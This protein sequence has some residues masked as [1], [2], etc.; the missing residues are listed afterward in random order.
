MFAKS[1]VSKLHYLTTHKMAPACALCLCILLDLHCYCSSSSWLVSQA[2]LQPAGCGP[3]AAAGTPHY[4]AQYPAP[5]GPSPCWGPA[6]ATCGWSTH[7]ASL[8]S[9]PSHTQVMQRM[10]A[11]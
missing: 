4:L 7:W 11:G 5:L 6:R 9:S 10:E 1:H 3:A 2:Q 8:C